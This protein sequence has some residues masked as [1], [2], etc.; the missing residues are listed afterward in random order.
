MFSGENY[1][2]KRPLLKRY[3]SCLFVSTVLICG[4]MG[5]F[6]SC[7][8]D[9]VTGSKVVPESLPGEPFIVNFTVSESVLGTGWVAT[10]NASPNPSVGAGFARPPETAVVPIADDL[11]MYATLK[12]E[13][14]PI[15]LR[16][17]AKLTTDTKV[18]VVA[19]PGA[20]SPVHADYEI[21]ANGVLQPIGNALAVTSSGSYSF[22]AYSYNDTNTMPV[23]TDPTAPIASRDVIWGKE[24]VAIS[25]ANPNVHI[26]LDHLFA[27][28]K[29]QAEVDPYLGNN[30]NQISDARFLH[31]FPVLTV[32][33]GLLTPGSTDTV[34]FTW[35]S[36][37]I[38]ASIWN[39]NYHPI[40]TDGGKPVVEI[41]SIEIDNV[42]Y[43]NGPY[44]VN[45]NT[46]LDAGKEYTLY[47]RFVKGANVTPSV[48]SLTGS[49]YTPTLQAGEVLSVT[50]TAPWTL[51]SDKPWLQLTLNPNGSGADASVS[52]SGNATVYLVVD[53]N[54]ST[55]DSRIAYI[56]QGNT[57]K[58]T[59]NQS[60]YD[61]CGYSERLTWDA[62]AYGGTGAYVLTTNFTD[63][64]LFFRF[65]SVVGIFSGLGSY[66]QVLPGTN[67]SNFNAATH[68]VWSPV[69]TIT[70][71]GAIG[72]ATIPY[73][74]TPYTGI[75]FP[76]NAAYHNVANVKAGLG[77]PCRLVG[78]DLNYIKN[79]PIGSLTLADIDNGEWRLPTKEENRD[80]LV[81]IQGIN[82]A[83]GDHWWGVSGQSVHPVSP[84]G[85]GVAGVEMPGRGLGGESKFL[86]A[87][88]MRSY[89]G[90]GEAGFF[91]SQGRYWSNETSPKV[92]SDDAA[93]SIGFNQGSV[94]GAGFGYYPIRHGFGVRCV[95][96]L[97]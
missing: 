5:V 12:E 46:Q 22:V 82:I 44:I 78:L 6:S 61:I 25:P 81:L 28:V 66:N 16:A 87:N 49:S 89:S 73:C 24:N 8:S 79:T 80:F 52:G 97:P 86:P 30:I 68:V 83:A 63:A 43:S 75:P 85:P 69:N 84:F 40:Y 4:I 35:P 26:N 42:P 1:S 47:V 53:G 17:A 50:S 70:G 36:G 54:P 91:G 72:W 94:S 95:R 10:R 13:D 59:V 48:I 23:F 2:R 71:T 74:D 62:T 93:Y 67:T 41:E 45:Y 18:R 88:G 27:Q 76:I 65:G 56:S 55:T 20:G 21:T 60:A 96:Q 3:N 32:Q 37:A 29:L 15:N 39:S 57:K 77:D 31:T 58:V 64:G 11:Y 7:G 19:Y 34:H 9:D 38:P 90:S 14:A 33:T 92:Q 51:T